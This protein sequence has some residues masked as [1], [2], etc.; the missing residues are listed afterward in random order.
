MGVFW[1]YSGFQLPTQKL[2]MHYNTPNINGKPFEI[3]PPNV[4]SDYV[5]YLLTQVG[6][7][8][9]TCATQVGLLEEAAGSNPKINALRL[10]KPTIYINSA[11]FTNL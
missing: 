8:E 6:L 2:K 10:L 3:Q 4:L 11:K 5:G 1:G 9:A 7:L